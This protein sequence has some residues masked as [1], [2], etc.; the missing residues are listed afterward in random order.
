[1]SA[2]LT[3]DA[4]DTDR[5]AVVIAEC[6]RME[7]PV[8]PPDIN[9]SVLK[10]AP[11]SNGPGIRF[12]LAS[13]KNV[14]AGAMESAVAEREKNGP[15]QSLANFCS[16]LDSRTVNRKILESLVKCGAFDCIEPNRASLFTEIE[17]AMGAAASLQRDRASGQ[18]SL[19]GDTPL[20][21]EK[22]SANLTKIAPWSQLETLGYEKELLGYYVSGHPLDAYAGHF[23]AGKYNTIAQAREATE[24]G[25]FKLAGL[26]ISVEKRFSK[27]DGKPFG[28]L[29]L[30]DFTG[31]LEITAWDESF[32][33]NASLFVVG[34]AVSIN[35]RITRRDEAIRATAG[36]VAA[37]K[38]KTSVKPVRL[39]LARERLAEADL[40]TILAAVKKHP[41]PRPLILE[42]V[43][44]NG[45][46]L[47]VPA[48][49]EFGVGDERG[50]FSRLPATLLA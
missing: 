28:I 3:F 38:P 49:E 25:T 32:S 39:R 29:M 26:V 33:K 27:K 18:V 40:D 11:E 35:T 21:P 13:I 19:F 41:G 14:G 7:I 12:G 17:P 10:F 44:P 43:L 36:A 23:D 30:E 4:N 15:F 22:K 6:R 37:L 20:V 34:S 45:R 31:S 24:P 8:R 48:G 9:T 5:L 42:F 47:E 16:R 1:M 50:L 2:M 46:S